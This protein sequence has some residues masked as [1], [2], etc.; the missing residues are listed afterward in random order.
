[1]VTNTQST[2]RVCIQS[3]PCRWRDWGS[4]ISF[5]SEHGKM[6]DSS[7]SPVECAYKRV[8]SA[9][10][11]TTSDDPRRHDLDYAAMLLL[12]E[13]DLRHD[14]PV[15]SCIP[16]PSISD[17]LIATGSLVDARRI[18]IYTRMNEIMNRAKIY[19]DDTK[20]QF[21]RAVA[22]PSSADTFRQEVYERGNGGIRQH[23]GVRHMIRAVSLIDGR[24]VDMSPNV[25]ST[26]EQEDKFEKAT[27]EFTTVFLKWREALAGDIIKH[28]PDIRVLFPPNTTPVA[29]FMVVTKSVL[30]DHFIHLVDSNLNLSL[31]I[32]LV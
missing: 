32:Q 19:E 15:L 16:S 29:P 4:H 10:E 6:T 26:M 24:L 31:A 18:E 25:Y 11:M 17:T 12:A 27:R 8:K 2:I 14:G 22:E 13:M 7:E 30:S 23:I 9:L 28:T 20:W 1:M 3:R 5:E 21:E